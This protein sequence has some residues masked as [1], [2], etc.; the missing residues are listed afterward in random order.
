MSNTFAARLGSR[1]DGRL[2]NLQEERRGEDGDSEATTHRSLTSVRA[3]TR[4]DCVI[5]F[6]I[7]VIL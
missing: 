3:R 4:T 5:V 1:F 2:H 7:R 6:N